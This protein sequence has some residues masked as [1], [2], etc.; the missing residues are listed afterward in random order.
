VRLYLLEQEKSL[1]RLREIR[2]IIAPHN[3]PLDFHAC[4]ADMKAHLA[5][6][7]LERVIE[8]LAT[9]V[10][11]AVRSLSEPALQPKYP[12]AKEAKS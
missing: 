5:T 6:L 4:V 7:P 12:V 10:E 9:D 2:S 8:L 1:A 11:L 3:V